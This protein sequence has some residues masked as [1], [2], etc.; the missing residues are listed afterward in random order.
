ILQLTETAV[1]SPSILNETRFQ[2][3]SSRRRQEGNASLP[4]IAVQQAFTSGGSSFGL[5]LNESDRIEL[6]NVTTGVRGQHTWKAG[7]RLRAL[8]ISDVAPSNFSGTFVFSSLEQYRQVLTGVP[9]VR[10]AQFSIA[11]GDPRAGVT[12]YDL[13]GFAQD[14][15]RMTPNFTLSYGLRFETQNNIHDRLDLA[16]RLSVAWAPIISSKSKRPTTV[17]RAGIGLFYFRVEDELT[18]NVNRF[19]GINQQQ[20]IVADP[21]FYPNIPTTAQLAAA[22]LQQT[23]RRIDPT[24]KTPY[25]IRSAISLEQKWA[26][27]TTLAVTYIYERDLQSLRSRNINAPLPGTFDP[28]VPGSGVRPYGNVGNIYLFEG[29]GLDTDN[30]V[31]VNLTTDLTKRISIFSNNGLSRETN[32]TEGAF[33]F[34]ANSYDLA[35]EYG[36]ASYDVRAFTTTGAN[37]K[38]PWSDMVWATMIRAASP[39]RFNITTGRD[40]NGDSIFNDRPAFAT[41]PTKPGVVVTPYGAFDP[42]PSPGQPLIPRNYGTGAGIFQVNMRLIKTFLFNLGGSGSKQA[43]AAGATGA[44]AARPAAQPPADKRYR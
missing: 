6:Q 18:L 44:G 31:F 34:P 19:N 2:F 38:L 26:R 41:D 43:V 21:D 22:A 42:N 14:D 33:D 28:A 24:L 25:S 7:G 27:N 12:Q 39:G 11:G 37:V 4:V 16:P 10:P 13:A 30:T 8:R 1:L 32:D 15:W 40:T 23:V 29:G 35:A 20:Y 9:G 5:A 3:I 36:R 17:I